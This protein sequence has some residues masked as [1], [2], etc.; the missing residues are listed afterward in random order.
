MDEGA[1]PGPGKARNGIAERHLSARAYEFAWGDHER[2]SVVAGTKVKKAGVDPRL[3]HL[4]PWPEWVSV[5][6]N[7]S[8]AVPLCVNR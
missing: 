4:G 5:S 8:L 6:A 3:L 1:G 2:E 7:R